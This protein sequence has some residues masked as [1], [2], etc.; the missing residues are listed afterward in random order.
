MNREVLGKVL[1]YWLSAGPDFSGLVKMGV[2][3]HPGA[4]KF[5]QEQEGVKIPPEL[6][7]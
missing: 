5:W 6:I 7:K 4:V 2:P 1:N 3:L